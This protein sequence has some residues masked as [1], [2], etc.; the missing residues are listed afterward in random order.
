MYI[1][2]NMFENIFNIVI[3]M[4][5]KTKENMKTRVNIPLFCHRKNMKLIH[6]TKFKASLFLDN[7]A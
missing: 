4:K 7:N 5:R 3:G 6:V 2:K 1:E